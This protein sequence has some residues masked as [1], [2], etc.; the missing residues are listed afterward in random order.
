MMNGVFPQKNS[1]DAQAIQEAVIFLVTKMLESG[2]NPKPVIFHS[3]RVGV[4]LYD[5]NYEPEVVKAGILHDIVEDSNT[6]LLEF[7]KQFG[8]RVA[9]I[10]EANT[11]NYTLIDRATQGKD[12]I[13]RCLNYGRDAL[14]V[15]VADKLENSC[16]LNLSMNIDFL[17]LWIGEMRYLV[18]VSQSKLIGLD[19]PIWNDLSQQCQKL[20]NALHEMTTRT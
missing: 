6:S 10:V 13:Q 8:T 5:L 17:K 7:T 4:Y 15:R 3:I 18:D 9:E 20:E 19:Q 12:C 1:R 14:V 16:Y 11:F 2:H